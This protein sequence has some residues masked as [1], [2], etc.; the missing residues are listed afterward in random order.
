MNL[1]KVYES[2]IHKIGRNQINALNPTFSSKVNSSAIKLI[3]PE[4]TNNYNSK[5]SR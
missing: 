1:D 2:V 3:T 4:K 5:H